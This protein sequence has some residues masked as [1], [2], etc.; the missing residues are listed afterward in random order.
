MASEAADLEWAR[1]DFATVTSTLDQVHSRLASALRAAH[2][3]NAELKQRISELEAST[4][5]IERLRAESRALAS[6]LVKRNKELGEREAKVDERE[7]LQKKLANMRRV[8]RDLLSEQKNALLPTDVADD[9]RSHVSDGVG[10]DSSS[11]TVRPHHSRTASTSS[12]PQTD[13]TIINEDVLPT[14][15]ASQSSSFSALHG[16]VPSGLG[17]AFEEDK[18]HRHAGKQRVASASNSP[19]GSPF[20][21]RSQTSDLL[22]PPRTLGRGPRPMAQAQ[23]SMRLSNLSMIELSPGSS[24]SGYS[25]REDRDDDMPVANR[26]KIHVAKPPRLAGG[27]T[28]PFEFRELSESF[29]LDVDEETV[30]ALDALSDEP[31]DSLRLH[32]ASSNKTGFLYDPNLLETPNGTYVVSWGSAKTNAKIAAYI[33]P[34]ARKE[35]LQMFMWS[36][37]KG[38]WFY[39]GKHKFTIPNIRAI[40]DVLTPHAQRTLA[41][42]HSGSSVA[43]FAALIKSGELKQLTVR[44]ERMGPV[45]A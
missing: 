15:P 1:K 10:V 11:A 25:M 2:T 41:A 27:N 26:W 18:T 40:W 14:P 44:L 30:S 32:I 12:S 28:G 29:G 4:G 36:T 42:K 23:G 35:G 13:V 45:S 22:T 20:A 17:P 5:D 7:M 3:E 43:E 19:A 16:P 39:L 9:I 8:M 24:E 6:E 34:D 38:G 33:A 37:K 21:P 31:T